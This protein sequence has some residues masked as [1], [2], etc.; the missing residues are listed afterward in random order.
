MS[1]NN[2]TEKK[3]PVYS[4]KYGVIEAALWENDSENGTYLTLSL[5]R[6]YKDA[7]GEWQS[8]NKSFRVND[9]PVIELALQDCFRHAKTSK[10]E[11]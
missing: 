7:K 1:E 5:S 3:K 8:T 9:L 2:N 4:S 10:K 6:N 11:E